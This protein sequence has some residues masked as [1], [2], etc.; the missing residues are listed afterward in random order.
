MRRTRLKKK[1]GVKDKKGGVVVTRKNDSLNIQL[2][3][4][5]METKHG[6]LLDTAISE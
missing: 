5:T 6:A 2:Q 1:Q 3:I 4:E